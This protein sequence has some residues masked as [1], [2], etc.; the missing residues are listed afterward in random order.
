LHFGHAFATYLEIIDNLTTCIDH[1]R[2][3][4][5]HEPIFDTCG[6][7]P[8]ITQYYFGSVPLRF[9]ILCIFFHT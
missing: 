2:L 1:H 4:I 9:E 7:E 5:E 8:Q 6:A 3:R